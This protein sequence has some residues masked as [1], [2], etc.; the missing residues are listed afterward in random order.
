MEEGK[1]KRRGKRRG[2]NSLFH[3]LL[4]WQSENSVALPAKVTIELSDE[5]SIKVSEVTFEYDP[6]ESVIAHAS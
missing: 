1:G 2:T 5:Q 3:Q 6:P 4:K